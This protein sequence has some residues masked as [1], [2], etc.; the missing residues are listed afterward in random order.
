MKVKAGLSVREMFALI[1]VDVEGEL[2]ARPFPGHVATDSRDVRPGG[3]FV[4]LEG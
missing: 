3:G 1:G 2:G 4:A